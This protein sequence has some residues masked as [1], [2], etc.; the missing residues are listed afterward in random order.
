[1]LQGLSRGLRFLMDFDSEYLLGMVCRDS[2]NQAILD[3]LRA[4]GAE[5]LLPK[6][7]HARV[8]KYGLKH[9]HVTR[10]R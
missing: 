7:I 10:S 9:H 5:G 3:V 8:A 2:R 6:D 1:M 4:A